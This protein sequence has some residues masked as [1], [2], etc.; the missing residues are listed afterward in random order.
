MSLMKADQLKHLSLEGRIK[1]SYEALYYNVES[2]DKEMDE[3]VR[4]NAKHSFR[5]YDVTL[6]D[7]PDQKTLRTIM[8]E[9]YQTSAREF[10][11]KTHTKINEARLEK[12]FD[13]FTK[14]H[15][16]FY[17]QSFNH[18][19]EKYAGEP[20]DFEADDV[21]MDRK[22]EE[23]GRPYHEPEID[24]NALE[25]MARVAGATVASPL[26]G[27][28]GLN[29]VVS[30]KRGSGVFYSAHAPN[31]APTHTAK[32]TYQQVKQEEAAAEEL[33]GNRVDQA[34][35]KY[36]RGRGDTNQKTTAGDAYG[37]DEPEDDGPEL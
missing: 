23:A 22:L 4:R 32:R 18:Y 16:Q 15:D 26:S 21:R 10:G 33:K 9:A 25:M 5:S 2:G 35:D 20:I 24:D 11:E 37:F 36:A 29:A 13:D 17:K 1:N 34:Y 12:E 19:E 7:K 14:D 28:S 31:V 8:L 30:G 6:A 3:V 27:V